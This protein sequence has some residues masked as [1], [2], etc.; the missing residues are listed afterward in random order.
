MIPHPGYDEKSR[1]S[2]RPTIT[3]KRTMMLYSFQSGLPNSLYCSFK[4]DCKCFCDSSTSGSFFIHGNSLER[5]HCASIQFFRSYE[6]GLL[7]VIV[8]ELKAQP[9]ADEHD[10]TNWQSEKKKI[11]KGDLKCI[12][13]FGI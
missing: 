11:G 9:T 13:S 1:V 7:S 12:R 8:E 6:K 5:I 10:N 4:T 2:H 3:T